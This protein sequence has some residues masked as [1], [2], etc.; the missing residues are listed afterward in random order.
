MNLG[1]AIQKRMAFLNIDKISI[2][3]MLQILKQNRNSKYQIRRF[4]D[5]YS[6]YFIK[7]VVG[8]TELC[9]ENI[10]F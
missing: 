7:N 3:I 5:H 2:F 1:K 6:Y 9:I 8:V 10:F 4:L